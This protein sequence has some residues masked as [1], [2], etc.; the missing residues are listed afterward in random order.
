MLKQEIEGYR[1]SPVQ[2]RIWRL[3]DAEG[4]CAYRVE[5]VVCIDGELDRARLS[6]AVEL[7]VE[8]HEALRTRLQTL[9]GVSV[10]VQVV[11]ERGR[12]DLGEYQESGGAAGVGESGGPGRLEEGLRLELVGESNGRHRLRIGAPS[13]CLDTISLNLVAR[14]I[15]QL[16]LGSQD[17]G[18]R[19]D[20]SGEEGPLQYP[21]VAEWMN[22]MAESDEAEDARSY[23]SGILA[24]RRNSLPRVPRGGG[25]LG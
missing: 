14:E 16:Y 12:V 3:A 10:P 1:I 13:V 2:R 7:V 24:S 11:E 23:W 6:R 5:A 25:G 22:E 9:P 18:R 17:G 8:R 15:A 21:D 19:S 4:W 20:V